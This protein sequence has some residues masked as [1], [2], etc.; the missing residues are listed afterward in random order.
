MASRADGVYVVY[1]NNESNESPITGSEAVLQIYSKA[2]LAAELH[3]PESGSSRFWAALCYDGASEQ[4]TLIDA[5]QASAP[6]CSS[7]CVCS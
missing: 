7:G 6:S 3:V 5:I 2:G 1:V 4:M